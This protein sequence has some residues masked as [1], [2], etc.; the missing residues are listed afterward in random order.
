VTIQISYSYEGCPTL[1][2]FADSD[3]FMR[4]LM[5]PF[6]SGKSSACVTEIV[7]RA[8]AQEPGPDGVRRSRWGV[9]RNTFGELT[10]TTLKTIFQWLPQ[11]YFGR[12]IER[13]KTYTV[14]AF[15]GCEFEI[16]LMALDRPDD[17]KRLLSLELTGAWV[18]EAREVPWGVIE[19]LQGRVGRYPSKKDGGA[20]WW[21]VWL[22][23][24]PP[25]AD[26]R[27]YRYFEEK[28]WLKDF[29]ELR[30]NGDLPKDMKPEHYA[31]IFKQPSGLSPDA[32]N[33]DNLPGGRLYYTN[34]AAGKSDEWK[35]IYIKGQYG[36]VVEGKLVYPEYSDTIHCRKADPVPGRTIIRSWDFGL[37]YS[38]DT[39]VLTSNGWKLFKDVD[40]DGDLAASRDPDTGEMAF[41]QIGFRIAQPFKG[42]MLHWR[43]TELDMLVTP[44]HRVPYTHRD[45]PDKV[46]WASA[47]WLSENMGRHHMVDLLAGWREPTERYWQL[48]SRSVAA[49][50]FAQFMGLYLAEGSTYAPKGKVN[51]YQKHRNPHM[52]RILLATGLPWRWVGEGKAAGWWVT[53][54]ALA[55]QLKA[56]GR[57]REKFVPP[58]V[59]AMGPMAIRSFIHAY[60][61]GDGHIRTRAN[62]AIEHT[63]YTTS[64]VMA[65]GMQELAQKA[66]WNSSLR[67]VKPQTSFLAGRRI[68][69]TGGYSITFK[70]RAARAE[71]HRRSFK[72]VPY[73]GMVYCLNVPWHTL[74]VR[75]GGKPHWNG[76]TP[77]CIFSQML[78][79]GQWLT[80]DEMTS[81]NMSV[82]E[83]GDNVIEHCTRAFKGSVSFE[84]WGDPAGQNRHETDKRSAFDILQAKSIDIRAALTQEP[85]LRQEAVRKPLRTLVSGEPQFILHPRCKVLRK[86]FMGGYHRRRL[87][88]AG[89]ERYS[90]KPEKNLYSHPHDALQY[91]MVEYFGPGLIETPQNDDDF[92]ERDSYGDAQNRN[93]ETGY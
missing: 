10:Q 84:D 20:T 24:N 54:H 11:A 8:L 66:G 72:R 79:T 89:P 12:Y 62:G 15:P 14:T 49:D 76:N 90:D 87:Q 29:E 83:F 35:K 19:V 59:R 88:T 70:K 22:D 55:A 9:V 41:H 36:F 82:D 73:D 30:R 46:R 64:K 91:G 6:G 92:Y 38:D 52:E 17:V 78:P 47:Q 26:S 53:D 2:E 93:D 27:W 1:Q 28:S 32:E 77:A 61:L 37:C 13:T 23:T 56:Y 50:V 57:A 75:R 67:I 40:L 3:A 48:G 16:V 45:H 44:E 69:N 42:D 85:T 74:Y 34:L 86:G 33:I 51:I 5:G 21:G 65:D 43:S 25:D 4:G 60:T 18:N 68:D 81:D 80:F 71:L 39:E 7:A 58:E 31:A 63:V